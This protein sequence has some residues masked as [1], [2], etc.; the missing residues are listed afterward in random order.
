MMAK[1]AQIPYRAERRNAM[2]RPCRG[3]KKLK[4]AIDIIQAHLI[5][6]PRDRKA[7]RVLLDRA[8]RHNPS[9]F[10][11]SSRAAVAGDLRPPTPFGAALFST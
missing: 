2:K 4:R 9:F 6:H 1:R 11:G 3:D 7:A 8:L 5:F 10:A